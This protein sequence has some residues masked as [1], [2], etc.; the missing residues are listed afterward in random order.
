MSGVAITPRGEAGWR[1]ENRQR[2]Q[3]RAARIRIEMDDLNGR[4]VA[5]K[6]TAV[7]AAD[8]NLVEELHSVGRN[9]PSYPGKSRALCAAC[10]LSASQW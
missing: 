6:Q 10:C 5:R 3:A 9:G 4:T 8:Y 7:M 1:E 2:N